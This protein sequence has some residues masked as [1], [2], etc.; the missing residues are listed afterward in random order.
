MVG[1]IIKWALIGSFIVVGVYFCWAIYQI[2]AWG[3]PYSSKKELIA[4]YQEKHSEIATLKRYF[5]SIVPDSLDVYIEYEEDNNI[6]LKVYRK[7]ADPANPFPTV[8]LFQEWN[9][10]PYNYQPD[11][12]AI[13]LS[14]DYTFQQTVQLLNWNDDTFRQIKRYLDKANCISVTN[15][16]PAQ[17]GFRRSGLGMYFYKLFDHPLTDSLQKV[18][19][20]S[21]SHILFNESVALEY[22]GGAVGPQCFPDAKE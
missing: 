13:G 4:N 19:N 12:N 10:D 15:G 6:D 5:Y 17:I 11:S 18:Y 3:A 16:D 7:P 20:D 14:Q 9:I 8:V 21:C 2:M 22:G 1:K